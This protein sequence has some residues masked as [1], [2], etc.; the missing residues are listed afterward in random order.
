MVQRHDM[1]RW[2]AAALTAAAAVLLAACSPG[3]GDA[4]GSAG[5][6][7][8]EDCQRYVQ[9][10]QQAGAVNDPS[11]ADAIVQVAGVLDE[12][13]DRVPAQ[14]S[15]DFRVMASAYQ[16]YADALQDLNTDFA[17][18]ESLSELDAE[19]VAALEAA[20]QTLN[21]PQVHDAATNIDAFLTEHCI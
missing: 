4:G 19:D 12:G 9:A 16:G 1:R 15:D 18:L 2:A 8:A 17:N 13:A 3:D 14:V 5:A 10:F 20:S 7:T 21:T 11:H 6:L